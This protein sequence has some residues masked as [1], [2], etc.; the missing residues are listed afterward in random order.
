MFNVKSVWVLN[1]K[2]SKCLQCVRLLF[3]PRNREWIWFGCDDDC[4]CNLYFFSSFAWLSYYVYCIIWNEGTRCDMWKHLVS[5]RQ[6]HSIKQNS[7]LAYIFPLCIHDKK[8]MHEKS[9]MAP[10]ANELWTQSTSTKHTFSIMEYGFYK[11]NIYAGCTDLDPG[12]HS[13]D[14]NQQS[15]L[16]LGPRILNSDKRCGCIASTNNLTGCKPEEKIRT[17]KTKIILFY[18]I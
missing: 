5:K 12:I 1:Q 17:N 7:S 2:W 18:F 11:L 9:L 13:K 3:K 8:N 10:N 16:S 15:C 4:R 14:N 6:C